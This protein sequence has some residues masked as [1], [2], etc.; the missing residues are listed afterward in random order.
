MDCVLLVLALP[1]MVHAQFN[2]VTNNGTVTI[3]GYTGPGGAVTIPAPPTACRSPASAPLHSNLCLSLTSVTIGASVTNIG[4]YAFGG[5]SEL[6]SATLSDRVA[7]VDRG[8]FYLCSSLTNITI[9]GSATI[10]GN[11]AFKRA[12]A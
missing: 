11:G 10:I 9:P 1:A 3:T 12:P 6:A 2:Y 8:A 4:D 7:S 5:C